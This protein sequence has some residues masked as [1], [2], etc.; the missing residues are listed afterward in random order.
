MVSEAGIKPLPEKSGSH[1]GLAQP[2]C[3]KDVRSLYGLCSYYR[4]FVRNF[5]GL[6]KP[7]ARLTKL[8][9]KFKWGSEEQLAFD[10]PKEALVSAT[11]LAVPS[12]HQVCILD[13]DASDIAIGAVLSQTVE[14]TERPIAFFRRILN[15][16][17]MNYC[18][19]RRELLAVIAAL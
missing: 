7:L 18:T 6:A 17:Q 19:T 10:A 13:T 3:L 9:V 12:P 15:K 2:K 5:A 8:N 4:K 11:S 14:G 1:T 16:T